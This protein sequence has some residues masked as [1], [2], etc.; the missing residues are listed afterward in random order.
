MALTNYLLQSIACTLFFTGF[1]MGYFGKLDQY[2]LYIVVFE[3]WIAQVV[4]S[5]IVVTTIQGRTR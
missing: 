4:F 3:I 2:Q 5:C 1:G